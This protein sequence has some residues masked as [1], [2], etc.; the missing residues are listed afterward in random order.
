MTYYARTYRTTED[1]LRVFSQP[2]DEAAEQTVAASLE[3]AW[4]CRLHRYPQFTPVD[5]YAERDG[6]L[7]GLVELKARQ[8][9]AG[10][11]PTVWLNVRKH[12]ALT[13]GSVCYGVP[14]VFVVQFTDG[15]RW[16]RVDEIDARRPVIGGCR[17]VVKAATDR[18]PVIEVPVEQLRPLASNTGGDDE[19]F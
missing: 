14:S 7:V 4:G 1:G 12:L 5:W 2:E 13:L 18:E 16:V 3:A 11:Y 17:A 15:V 6:R 19:R 8:H 9:H 10:Q